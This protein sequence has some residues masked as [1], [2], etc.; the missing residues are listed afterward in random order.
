M[1]LLPP[2]SFLLPAWLVRGMS[3]DRFEEWQRAIAFY[4]VEPTDSYNY[5]ETGVRI[6]VGK[7]ERM[8]TASNAT[9][10][11]A[12]KDTSRE[13]ATVAEVIPSD[14]AVGPPLVILAGKMIQQR[15]ITQIDVLENYIFSASDTAY[16]NDQL[17][18]EWAIKFEE[19]SSRRQ[20]NRN[21]ILLLDTSHFTR[22][23]IEFCDHHLIV[24]FATIPHT[25]HICQPLDVVVFQPYK[26][27]Y[28]SMKQLHHAMQRTCVRC[29]IGSTTKKG[30]TQI[31]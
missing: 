20:L 28:A 2:G 30:G 25:T 8:M 12:A 9:R 3:R 1:Y 16:I 6:G 29:I 4:N 23:F 7:K 14:G 26:Q 19:W 21:R 27:Y 13:S 11:T 10:L 31:C 15:W 22:Q 5:D 24:L 18:L 17:L